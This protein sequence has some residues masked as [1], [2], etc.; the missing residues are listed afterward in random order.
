MSTRAQKHHIAE[1]KSVV[2]SLTA[3]MKLL[4]SSMKPAEAASKLIAFIKKSPC[5]PIMADD[6]PLETNDNLYLLSRTW[7]VWQEEKW[8]D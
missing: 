4:E 6:N 1:L 8:T 5:D 3:E 2:D 7:Q